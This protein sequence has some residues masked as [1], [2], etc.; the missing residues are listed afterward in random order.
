MLLMLGLAVGWPAFAMAEPAAL[1]QARDAFERRQYDRVLVLVEPLIK[2]AAPEARKLKVRSLVRLERPVDALAA[3]DGLDG[4]G[5]RSE[6]ALLR[7]VAFGFITP[8]LKDMR[9]Q[10]RG[11]AYT[12]LKEVHTEET[13]PYLEDGLGDG[14][15]LVRAL[16]AEALG[17]LKAGQRSARLRKAIDDQAAMVRVAVLKALGRS[18]DKTVIALVEKSLNDE[19][20][21]VRMAAAEALIRLGRSELWPRILEAAKAPNPE[22]RGAALHIL[23][24]LRDK[25]ALPV[26]KQA[27][28]DTQPSVRG[29]AALAVGDLED[30]EPVPALIRALKD[31]VPGVRGAAAISLGKLHAVA[32]RSELTKTLADQNPGVRADAVAVLLELGAPYDEVAGTVRELTGSQD[33]GVRARVT[34]SLGKARAG[35]L[36]EAL[37]T[38]Q[39]QAQDPLP[40]PRIAAARALGQV[41]ERETIPI[42]RQVLHDQDEAVRATAGGALVRLLDRVVTAKNH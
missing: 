23:G 9:E 34:R 2:G 37:Q 21:T 42:L 17:R 32:A 8:V 35:S 29:A 3:Y 4:N 11:A 12:A 15:G 16:A 33:P 25:R 41:G 24:E 5:G 40:Q 10:M 39:L 31:P 22:E 1:Q 26:L 36:K 19:Q 6:T 7:E 28:E 18:G 38:L 30:P 27:L 13:I 20:A 14:S